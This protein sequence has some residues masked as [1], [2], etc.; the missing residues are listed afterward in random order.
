[1]NTKLNAEYW[2]SRYIDNRMGW[3]IGY[4]SKPIKTYVDQL[5]DKTISILIPGGGNA[6]EAE[7]LHNQGFKNVT[8]VDIAPVTKQGFLDRAPHFPEHH[9]IVKDFFELEGQFDLILEQTFFCALA[10]ELRK[11]Y[12]VKMHELLK[13]HGKLVGLLFDFPLKDGPPFGGSKTEY[14]GYFDSLFNSN[15]FEKC[16]N[17]IKPREGKEFFI[18]LSKR[19]A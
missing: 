10:P 11:S 4:P 12:A 14:L 9:F 6:Y 5:Q 7:Y 3:D 18:N 16:I 8:V 19:I 13:P 15:V 1:M 17:S 2:N